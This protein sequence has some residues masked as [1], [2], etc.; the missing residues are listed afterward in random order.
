MT[1]LDGP[2]D[3]SQA[4]TRGF[5]AVDSGRYNAEVFQIDIDAVKNT[6]GE[7]KMPA[8]TPMIKIQYKLLS[9][10]YGSDD[11][12]NRRVF[13]SLVIPPKDYDQSKA[14]KMQGMIVNTLVAL[15]EAEEKVRNPKFRPDFSEYVGRPCVLVVGKE[16][17]KDSRGNVIEGEFNN[18]VKGVK[19]AGSIGS[20]EAAGSAGLL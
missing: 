9:D 4:D 15:G 13:Q 14:Q 16:P 19:P 2:L 1:Q 3:L 12:N 11:C 6:S 7:G 20:G 17:K 8:G 10:A 18:P 5:E